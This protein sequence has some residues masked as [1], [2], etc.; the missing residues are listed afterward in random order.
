MK[1]IIKRKKCKF[2]KII[3]K[4]PCC[5]K[6]NFIVILLWLIVQHTFIHFQVFQLYFRVPWPNFL[7]YSATRLLLWIIIIFSATVLWKLIT[8]FANIFD[9]SKTEGTKSL[10]ICTRTISSISFLKFYTTIVDYAPREWSA[11]FL[12]EVQQQAFQESP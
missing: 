6:K 11:W 5:Y 4:F 1:I 3:R 12:P 8:N 2:T 9:Y 10:I 7:K